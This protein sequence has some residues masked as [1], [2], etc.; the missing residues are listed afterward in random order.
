MKKVKHKYSLG[1]IV[2]IDWIGG[3]KFT[4]EITQLTYMGERVNQPNYNLPQY[5]VTVKSNPASRAA[6]THYPV[7]DERIL[8]VNGKSTE[9]L[10]EKLNTKRKSSLEI[11]NLKSK[12]TRKKSK[13]KSELD[14]AINDQKDFI[15][16]NVKKDSI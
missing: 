10:S 5:L 13:A 7:S 15:R 12:K 4:G 2:T 16:G 8:S 11:S 14:Q 1:D 3:G 6:Y 9:L